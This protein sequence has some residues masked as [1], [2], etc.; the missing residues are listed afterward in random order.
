MNMRAIM[1]LK[2]EN[3]EKANRP[4]FSSP[5]RFHS[6]SRLGNRS[7]H[8]VLVHRSAFE[9]ERAQ[10]MFLCGAWAHKRVTGIQPSFSVASGMHNAV[11]AE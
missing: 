10:R 7:N 5:G 6:R 4:Q 9:L 11:V 3:E 1:Q 2:A 8:V